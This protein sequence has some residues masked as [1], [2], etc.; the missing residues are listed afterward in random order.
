MVLVALGVISSEVARAQTYAITDYLVRKIDAPDAQGLGSGPYFSAVTGTNV[1]ASDYYGEWVSQGYQVPFNFR[2]LNQQI[3]TSG[4]FEVNSYGSV[5]FSPNWPSSARYD[6]GGYYWFWE[7]YYG[8]VYSYAYGLIDNEIDYPYGYSYYPNYKLCPFEGFES[9]GYGAVNPDIEWAV[10][11]SAPTRELVVTAKGVGAYAYGPSAGLKGDWQTVVYEGG[12]SNF[13]FNYGTTSGNF[14]QSWGYFYNGGSYQ[15]T[16]GGYT[17]VKAT[18]NNYVSIGWNANGWDETRQPVVSYNSGPN[19]NDTTAHLPLS[20]WRV[21]IAWNYDFSAD[22]IT[23]PPNE[24]PEPI[25][26]PFTPTVQITNQ[27][28]NTPT[29]LQVNLTMSILNG[30]QVYNQ[31]VT[32][33]TP[34]GAFTSQTVSFPAFTPQNVTINGVTYPGYNIYEDTAIVFNLQPTADQDASN[35]TTTNEWICAPPNDIKAVQILSP[36]VGTGSANRTPLAIASPVDIRFRNLG[37]A[38]QTNV[39]ITAVIRDP[40]GTVVYRDTVI[41]PYWPAGPTGGNSD[42]SADYSNAGQGPGKGAYYDTSFA[43]FTP[44]VVGTHKVCGIA[45]MATDQLRG[46]DTVCG[47]VLV[48]PIYDAAANSVVNPQPDEEKPTG[49]SWQPAAL[50]QSTGVTDLFDVPVEVQIRR[51]SDGGLVFLA[52]SSIPEL[53]IDQNLV[54]FYFPSDAGVYHISNIQPGCYTICAIAKYPQ[55]GDH[56]NDTACSEFSVISKLS[57]DIYV[58]VGQRF[59]TIHAAVDSMRFRGVGGPLRLILKDANY[60]ENGTSRVAS[61][62]GALDMRGINGV[63][64]TN[65]VSWVPYPG[66]TP[67]ITFTGSEPSCFYFGDLFG[68]YMTFEGYNP[69]GVPIPDKLTAEPNKRGIT[70][71]DNET[72][73]GPVFDIE[74]GASHITLKDLII[75]GNGNFTDDSSAVVRIYNEHNMTIFLQQVR[76]TVPINHITINNCEIGNAKYGL[77]DHGLHDQFNIG[78]S[79]FIVWRNNSNLI[80][81]N[82]IGTAA[83][84]ISYAGIQFNNEQD[85]TIS[86]NEISN[87]DVANAGATGS[88]W[89]AYGIESPS[90]ASYIGGFPFPVLNGDTGNVV[91]VWIDANRIRNI[92]SNTGNTYGIAIQQAV[93]IYGVGQGV[94]AVHSSLPVITQNRVTNNMIFDLRSSGNVY[95]IYMNTAGAAYSADLDSVFNNSISTKNATAN[96]SM[97]FEKHAFLWNNILQNTSAGPYTNYVLEVP[98]PYASSISSDYNLF[99]LRGTNTFASVT[100]YDVRYG[101][102]IQTRTFRRL[103]D[104]R[105]YLGQDTHSLTGD[106]MFASPA[107]GTDSLHMPPALTYIESPASNNGFWLGT[108]TQQRDFDGELRLQGNLTPDI[109]ADEW[110]GFQYTNDLAVLSINQPA[111]ASQSSDTALVTTESPLW[112]NATVKNLSSQAVFN[113]SVTAKVEAATNGGPWSTIYSSTTAPMTWD[114]NQAQNVVFQGPALTPNL[115]KNTVFR[116]TVSVPSDQNNPN[117]SQV[118]VF[119]IILKTQAVIVSYNGATPA[120]LANLAA[121]HT[122][123]NNLG[124]PYDSIDRNAPNGLAATTDVDYRPWWTLVWASGDP[125]IAPVAGQ[126]TGQ[127][128]LSFKETDEI[129]RYLSQGLS[130]AKKNL[131]IAGQN[132]AYWNGFVQVNNAVTDTAW[133]QGTMHTMFVANSPVSG[134]YIGKIVGQQPAYWKFPDSINSAS[135]DVVKPSFFTPAVGPQVTGFAYSYATHPLTPNDSGAGTTYYDNLVN[136]VFYGFDWSNPYMTTPAGAGDTTSG[137]TRVLAGALSFFESHAGTILGVEFVNENAYHS[138]ANTAAVT[139][140]VSGQ[141]DVAQYDVEQQASVVDGQPTWTKIGSVNAVDN[142]NNYAFTATNIDAAQSY[143]FRIAAVDKSGA[144]TYSNNVELGP[145]A[146]NLGFTLGQNYPNPTSGMTQIS[147]TLPEASHVTVRVLDVTGKVVNSDVTNASFDAGQQAVQLDLSSLTSGSYVYELV[148]TGSDGQTITLSK[149]LT[150]QK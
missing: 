119:S 50:F 36:S 116:L 131:V 143:T 3:T 57:G 63:S 37:T 15:Y 77:Y 47:P 21:F 40:S 39:P 72:T 27:G 102:V 94:N 23:N 70:I 66:V 64:A 81:R 2:F 82:T 113:R 83:N 17:A 136:T 56:S 134:T 112:I 129:N 97:I 123:L 148:A 26:T 124:I 62:F 114:V 90:P 6:Y 105:T 10:V 107:M 74:E 58:G 69:L 32:V 16:Y 91:R 33:T 38:D 61:P 52:D 144:K 130:Y 87:V 96:I 149:K 92:H 108:A 89:N 85:L 135:P 100:E 132:I 59:Q 25:N 99:D 84:P 51:C 43:Q 71:V 12:I 8:Y 28:R 7:Y 145:D 44:A 67:T 98:R 13:Q 41:I 104:W 142:L 140:E 11:G 14:S 20:G 110:D 147:F 141:K 46:D 5:I 18:G 120:G 101:T 48:R 54:R 4:T 60:T 55:D 118:K 109:G 73:P 95:P 139:W 80:T 79:K 42:G 53:N 31:T 111:G 24:A 76:D 86:H 150:I 127:A 117:N 1:G 137:V 133:L 49:I 126:P 138:G 35:N 115:V 65:T 78:Q 128:G 30:P 122:A 19:N 93:T 34:P 9:G 29:S 125:T 103:N 106:P 121:V 75:H 146:S 22:K 88:S 68:G 45:I